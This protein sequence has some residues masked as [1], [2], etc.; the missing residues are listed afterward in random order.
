ML[1]VEIALTL[2]ADIFIMKGSTLC[3]NLREILSTYSIMTEEMHWQERFQFATATKRH[4]QYK[5]RLLDY[6]I[7]EK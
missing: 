6:M 5:N 2:T 1:V 3:W 4:Q 7:R